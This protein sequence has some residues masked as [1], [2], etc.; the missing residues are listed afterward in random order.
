MDDVVG[1]LDLISSN[2][3][4]LIDETLCI[5]CDNCVSAC[6]ATHGGYSRLNRRRGPSLAYVHVPVA[7]RHCENAPCLQ[8]CDAGDAIM[9]DAD[10]VVQIYNHCIGC[11]HCEQD[12]PYGVISMVKVEAEK[13]SDLLPTKPGREAPPPPQENKS[14]AEIALKCDVC[15]NIAGGPAC[16]RHC[17]TG[18]AMRVG[19]DDLQAT[20]TRI[21]HNA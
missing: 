1:R 14:I 8:R 15:F 3:V 7:C 13:I 9:R 4:L 21:M 10:G 20:V 19:R 6:A 18:A 11:G 16:V 2:N 12:C 17:P 5:K